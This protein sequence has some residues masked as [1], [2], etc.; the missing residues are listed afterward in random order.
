MLV[1]MID[2]ILKLLDTTD[3]GVVIATMIEWAAAVDRLDLTLV[4]KKFIKLGVRPSLIP[5]LVSYLSERRMK[6]KFNLM[7]QYLTDQIFLISQTTQ[8]NLDSISAFIFL[9][10]Y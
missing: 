7:V 5:L 3:S 9:F 6:V 8:S 10:I 1:F 2:R 4:I